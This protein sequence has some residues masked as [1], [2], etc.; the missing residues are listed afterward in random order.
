MFPE[1]EQLRVPAEPQI[2][3][4]QPGNTK[5][6]VLNAPTLHRIL[7]KNLWNYVNNR[8]ISV[9]FTVETFKNTETTRLIF[10]YQQVAVRLYE[11]YEVLYLHSLPT[12]LGTPAEF[13]EYRSLEENARLVP[14]IRGE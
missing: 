9:T 10:F 14:Q 5:R 2:P 4:L 12:L 3:P 8:N 13:T 11:L 1:L 6:R 7:R